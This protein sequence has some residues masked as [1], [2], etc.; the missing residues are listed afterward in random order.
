MSSSK[1]LN[2]PNKF[3]HVCGSVMF[4]GESRVISESFISL[5]YQYFK[6]D[7]SD[8]DKNY[9]PD[10]VCSSCYTSLR[11][12]ST[13]ARKSMPFGAPMVWSRSRNHPKDCYFCNC[14]IGGHNRANRKFIEYPDFMSSIRP[15]PHGP[16]LPVPPAPWS[17]EEELLED[18]IMAFY[19]TLNNPAYPPKLKV[20][21]MV[22]GKPYRILAGRM[23]NSPWG[24]TCLL[25]I[26]D[27]EQIRT[28]YLPQKI[29]QSVKANSR[30]ILPAFNSGKDF[31]THRGNFD[32]TFVQAVEG[33]DQ[34][35]ESELMEEDEDDTQR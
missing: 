23:V 25:E 9:V 17:R 10:F 34:D 31:V 1:C 21:N 20:V 8:L 28:I 12:W 16:E 32:L 22:I 18:W 11:L 5:Y 15:L 13:G 7:V 4:K 6:R 3:C 35:E 19:Q 24:E 29:S 2:N 33:E 26:Q 30:Q 27:G 14:K